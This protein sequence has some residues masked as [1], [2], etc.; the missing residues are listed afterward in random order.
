MRGREAKFFSVSDHAGQTGE[1]LGGEFCIFGKILWW[2]SWILLW[3]RSRFASWSSF[4]FVKHAS[5]FEFCLW[6]QIRNS[7][8]IC[9]NFWKFKIE[10]SL[11]QILKFR[12]FKQFCFEFRNFE[13]W[14]KVA[15]TF[16]F[17]IFEAKM[18]Q[19]LKILLFEASLLQFLKF[20]L[21]FEIRTWKFQTWKFQT[22][23]KLEAKFCFKEFFKK[24]GPQAR[25]D[26]HLKL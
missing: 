4:C 24:R 25:A 12:N 8:Q 20:F 5:Y 7:K 10:A 26:I 23:P 21:K 17:F 9:F 14:S 1:E 19:F 16:E 11:L 6:S 18:L 22:H 15:S 3:I 2:V 13:T